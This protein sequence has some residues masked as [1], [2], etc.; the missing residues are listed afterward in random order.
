MLRKSGT[1]F[2]QDSILKGEGHRGTNDLMRAIPGFMITVL[3]TVSTDESSL[4]INFA[5]IME[6]TRNSDLS[7]S[8]L[9]YVVARAR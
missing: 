5:G 7:F 1:V 6:I 4:G 2:G 3:A 8:G 9:V